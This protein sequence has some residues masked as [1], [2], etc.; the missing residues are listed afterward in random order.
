MFTTLVAHPL[1]FVRLF[2]SCLADMPPT[3]I[4]SAISGSLSFVLLIYDVLD[5]NRIK[6]C[7]NKASLAPF[8]NVSLAQI[9]F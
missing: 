3:F 2:F 9:V 7:H 5:L 1:A 4:S 6:S 8:P